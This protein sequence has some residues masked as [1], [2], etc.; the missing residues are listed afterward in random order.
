MK[1][2]LV[3][4]CLDKSGPGEVCANLL[5]SSD[6]RLR[7]FVLSL[8]NA[9]IVL[10]LPNVRYLPS[11]NITLTGQL[12]HLKTIIMG[13]VED[14]EID[15][16]HSHLLFA[17]CFKWYIPHIQTIHIYPG[18]QN[19]MRYG[20]IKGQLINRFMELSLRN[21]SII[22]VACSE[23]LSNRLKLEKGLKTYAIRNGIISNLKIEESSYSDPP[24]LVVLSRLERDKNIRKIANFAVANKRTIDFYGKGSEVD[25][26][27]K[28]KSPYVNYCGFTDNPEKTLSQY[29]VF[30][31]A[32]L[33]EGFPIA[34]LQ[35][36]C[37]GC[38]VLLSNIPPHKELS[39]LFPKGVILFEEE[40][41]YSLQVI[42]KKVLDSWHANSSDKYERAL[43]ARRVFNA[44]EM[45]QKYLNLYECFQY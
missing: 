45:Y 44:N 9:E 15:L 3:I 33:D 6:E 19:I 22:S 13:H 2:L 36:L 8:K 5:R 35:A 34:V 16:V 27:D 39:L 43:M 23:A 30:I 20:Y 42:A 32:S 40:P 12:L 14:L 38:K 7:Y 37:V 29:D 10:D 25:Y 17:G 41:E 26:L 11:P 4:N 21:S 28:L 1:V 18:L 24:K 31:S